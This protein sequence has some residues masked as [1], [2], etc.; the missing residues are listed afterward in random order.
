MNHKIKI[1]LIEEIPLNKK[2]FLINYQEGFKTK[3]Y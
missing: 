1:I 3:I 2:S